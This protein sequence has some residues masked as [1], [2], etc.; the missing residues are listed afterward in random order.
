MRVRRVGGKIY[1]A[2]NIFEAVDEATIFSLGS[3]GFIDAK[4]EEANWFDIKSPMAYKIKVLLPF[5]DEIIVIMPR[6]LVLDIVKNLF[7]ESF[8]S[9]DQNLIFDGLAEYLNVMAGA[10]FQN[11]A[12]KM[13]FELGI[14]EAVEINKLN[15]STYDQQTYIT[16]KE[17]IICIAHKLK[18]FN[19]E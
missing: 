17:Q 4:P 9:T 8:D 2:K 11:A 14:P 16:S 19:F 7:N 3:M 10:I 15:V 1:M 13:L 6:D 5:L 12:P 18:N